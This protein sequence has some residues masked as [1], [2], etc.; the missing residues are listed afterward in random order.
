MKQKN[1][2]RASDGDARNILVL[3]NHLYVAEQAAA[4][5][6]AERIAMDPPKAL[7]AVISPQNVGGWSGGKRRAFGEEGGGAPCP[8][9]FL[10][11]REKR[12]TDPNGPTRAYRSHSQNTKSPS[13]LEP[14]KDGDDD[15]GPPSSVM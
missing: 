9:E 13:N 10:L 11:K 3:Q 12:T 5:A 14:Y 7:M 1:H 2:L 6:V 4:H 15:E 8:S